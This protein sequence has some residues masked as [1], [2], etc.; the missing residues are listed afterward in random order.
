MKNYIDIKNKKKIN[1][2]SLIQ[3]VGA[4]ILFTLILIYYIVTI[5]YL[6]S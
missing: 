5:N 6:M 4:A 2:Y 3:K 1:K